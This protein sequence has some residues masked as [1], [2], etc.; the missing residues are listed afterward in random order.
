M[1]LQQG[2]LCLDNAKWSSRLGT[3]ASHQPVLNGAHPPSSSPGSC[4][5]GATSAGVDGE[6]PLPP[7]SSQD[8]PLPPTSQDPLLTVGPDDSEDSDV[9]VSTESEVT[10]A[11][12]PQSNSPPQAP[13]PPP[14]SQDSSA[15]MDSDVSERSESDVATSDSAQSV[16]PLQHL[17]DAEVVEFEIRNEK[18]GVKYTTDGRAGWTPMSIRNRFSTRSDEYDVKYLRRCKQIRIYNHMKRLAGEL[19]LNLDPPYF[20][21]QLQLE[22]VLELVEM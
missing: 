10:I 8:S 6:V 9:S 2:G 5:S 13:L 11:D 20:Q 16:G 19:A 1:E 4:S 17:E 12:S 7:T 18:P 22:P 15:T 21:H 3:L 14:S